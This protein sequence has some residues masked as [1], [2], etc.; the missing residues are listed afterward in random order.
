MQLSYVDGEDQGEF[1][2][3]KRYYDTLTKYITDEADK[4]AKSS[5]LDTGDDGGASTPNADGQV[6]EVDDDGLEKLR[7]EGPVLVK[8]FAPWCPQ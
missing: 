5:R 6:K 7:E 3:E 8:F 2:A 1:P 4:Y